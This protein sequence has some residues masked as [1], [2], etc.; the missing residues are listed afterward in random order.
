MCARVRRMLLGLGKCVRHRCCCLLW[1][2]YTVDVCVAVGGCVVWRCV[3]EFEGVW[4]EMG[5][6]CLFS[7][8]GCIHARIADLSLVLSSLNLCPVYVVWGVLWCRV[9]LD[10]VGWRAHVLVG[11][12]EREG[13]DER[14]F[15]ST[16]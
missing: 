1:A 15:M 9:V 13:E 5:V 8:R 11:P 10:G 2:L 6:V 14:A 12:W 16:D 4:G 3:R 7:C